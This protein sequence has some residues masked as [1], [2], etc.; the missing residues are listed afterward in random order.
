MRRFALAS[1]SQGLP[2][3]QGFRFEMFRILGFRVLGFI[4]VRVNGVVLL[5]GWSFQGIMAAP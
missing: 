2:G 1:H 5:E 3:F 4:G